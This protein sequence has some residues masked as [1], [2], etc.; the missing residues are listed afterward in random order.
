MY[1]KDV[2]EDIVQGVWE[3]AHGD[4]QV[5][6]D[7]MN[8]LLM[9]SKEGHTERREQPSGVVTSPPVLHQSTPYMASSPVLSSAPLE[10]AKV[11]QGD[12]VRKREEAYF[13]NVA[14]RTMAHL[15]SLAYHRGNRA[16]AKDLSHKSR[17]MLRQATEANAAA[18]K[19]LELS[20]RN[21]DIAVLDLHGFH[22]E[23]AMGVLKRRI[24]LCQSRGTRTLRVITGYGHHSKMGEG[25]IRNTV[26][27]FLRD[28]G[29]KLE[30]RTHN[31]GP[32]EVT[33]AFRPKF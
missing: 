2:Q 11:L 20:E 14:R 22:V 13:A 32:G 10:H 4:M 28:E 30:L 7:M 24:H 31:T 21:A 12:W 18:M 23:E 33:I 3:T 25:K 6:M 26:L 19:L 15:S 29:D 8:E 16:L 5:A 9:E 17:Q 1:E 27:Q